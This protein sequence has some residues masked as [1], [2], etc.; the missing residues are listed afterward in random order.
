MS[1]I[2]NLIENLEK[3]ESVLKPQLVRLGISSSAALV[4]MCLCE[5][6]EITDIVKEKYLIELF[7]VGFA[8]VKNE[9][10]EVTNK[11][12]IVAKSLSITLS[13]NEL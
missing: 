2:L 12:L 9:K 11:G 13:K 5:G 6:K 7:E 4:L 8:E 3:F 1:F 10:I